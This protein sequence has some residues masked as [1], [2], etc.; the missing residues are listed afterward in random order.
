[1]QPTSTANRVHRKASCS[2]GV[3]WV[4]GKQNLSELRRVFIH[5]AQITD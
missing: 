3:L 4:S 1:M 5:I 2:V